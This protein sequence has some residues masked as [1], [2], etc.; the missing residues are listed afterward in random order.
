MN[1]KDKKEDCTMVNIK[2]IDI[3]SLTCND[4]NPRTISEQKFSKLVASIK[5]FPEMLEKRPIVYDSS[6]NNMI[7]GG[8]MRFLAAKAAELQAIPAIDAA[9]WDDKQKKQFIIKDNV[10]GGE[11][12][13]DILSVDYGIDELNEWGLDVPNLNLEEDNKNEVDEKKI[14]NEYSL[15]VTVKNEIE[16]EKLYRQLV[17]DGYQC[18][19]FS[20]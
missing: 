12:D 20:I 15:L 6:N 1:K 18:K 4:K 19:V 10:S 7:L 11:W 14:D 9:D 13:W 5:E 3:Q 8:N 16:Q 17:A 2:Y